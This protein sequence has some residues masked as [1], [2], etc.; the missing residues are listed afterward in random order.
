MKTNAK[1]PLPVI[2]DT[3]IGTDIDDL[4]ALVMMLKSPE[5]DIKLIVSATGD[6]LYRAAIIAKTLEIAGRTDIPI[7]VGVP[8]NNFGD[9]HKEWLGNYDLNNYDGIIYQNG[10]QSIVD[11]IINSPREIQLI[12]IGPLNNIWEALKLNPA[13]TKN[14]KFIGMHG[15]LFRGERENLTPKAE[16]NVKHHIQASQE[17]FKA[18]W[19]KLITPLDTCGNILLE[20]KRYKTLKSSDDKLLKEIF[21]CYESW[22]TKI[23]YGPFEFNSASSILF[24]TVAIFLAFSEEWLECKELPI[25]VTDKGFTVIDQN[26]SNTKVALHWKNK[27]AYLDFL[28][29]RLLSP[30]VKPLRI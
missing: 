5:I 14:C 20:G 26:G 29:E 13:I 30:T 21:K 11:T 16:Y 24:D 1:L 7:G 28:V 9:T 25:L 4:W 8:E 22:I 27:E 15:S 23:K 10:V 17:V 2:L 19:P 12:S 18:S 3:D 6:T